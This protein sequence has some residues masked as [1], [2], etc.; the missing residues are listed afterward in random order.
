MKKYNLIYPE[1][2]KYKKII[3]SK[4]KKHF[5]RK[6]KRKSKKLLLIILLSILISLIIILFI[7]FS[8]IHLSPFDKIK[9]IK[10]EK[11]IIPNIKVC[12]CTL[13]KL[14][15][16]YIREFVQ[17]Y[18][19]YGV[20]KIFLYDNNDINGEKFEEV[21]NDYI[22]KGFVEVLNWRGK[23]QAMMPIMNDCYNQNNKNYDWLIFYEIDEY[24]H[25]YNYTNVKLFLN[26]SKFANCQQILLN[27]VCHTDNNQL[28]YK[29]EPLKKR[30]PETVPITK[31]RGIHL[32][33]KAIIRGHIQG[34]HIN[35]NHLGDER[36]GGCDN[37]GFY[38]EKHGISTT[39]T[40][41]KYYYI[42]HYYSKS[43]EE[44][45][46]KLTKGD[47]LRNDHWYIHERI[48]KYFGQSKITKEK[49]DMIEQKTKIKLYKYRKMINY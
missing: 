8:K 3:Y 4:K 10:N 9:N 29:N 2:K 46:I 5:H 15:N 48:A 21:I 23:Y 7:K 34:L 40:D 38:E 33:Y 36:L 16:R 27:M 45:I 39:K 24:I 6:P 19:N 20:D 12:V 41:R 14:E 43:T 32:E 49:I 42:D 11:Q 17:H 1:S 35:N 44:F 13:A 47:A 22:K 18:E 30:F 26:Q 28:Y 25:L 37:S 31:P